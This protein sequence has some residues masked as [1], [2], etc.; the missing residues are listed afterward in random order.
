MAIS[1]VR[2]RGRAVPAG[3]VAPEPDLPAE[4]LAIGLPDLDVTN[5]PVCGRPIA[6]GAWTCP[7]CGT[8]LLLGVPARRAGT[9]VVLG[10][11]LGLV[12]GAGSAAA[13]VGR[14]SQSGVQ[15]GAGGTPAASGSVA[16]ASPQTSAQPS[17]TPRA[18]PGVPAGATAALGQILVTTD[19]LVA[20]AAELRAE[21][22][23]ASFNSFAVATTL[24]ALNAD[25]VAGRG[26]V[27]LLR[28]WPAATETADRVDA[29]YALVS[30]TAAQSL[31]SSLSDPAAYRAGATAMLRVLAGLDQVRS[32]SDALAG[33]AGVA[34]PVPSIATGP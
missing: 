9:F 15:P 3:S 27:G 7:G 18:S 2:R 33:L 8:R 34:T 5:C 31:A 30:D 22:A 23:A 16:P 29:A 1:T 21:L 6:V 32:A 13:V 10:L 14:P 26:V 28:P 11:V 24:R 12:V 4:P 20:R 25:A 19:R 17:P